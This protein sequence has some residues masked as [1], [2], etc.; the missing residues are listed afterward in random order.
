MQRE[1]KRTWEHEI[2][3]VVTLVPAHAH[4]VNN[5][6]HSGCIYS[7]CPLGLR[8]RAGRGAVPPR[9]PSRT[10]WS[11]AVPGWSLWEPVA[12]LV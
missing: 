9:E 11:W 12:A 8:G 5:S 7:H 10:G 1:K 4:P 3:A 2:G 6:S